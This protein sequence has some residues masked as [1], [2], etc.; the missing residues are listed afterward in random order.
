MEL[1]QLEAFER[2][3]REGSFTRTA[4]LLGLT[5]PA[6]STRIQLLETQLGGALFTRGGRRLTLT[7]LGEHF[8]PYAQRILALRDDSLQAVQDFYGGMRG[9]VKLAAPTPFL[10]SYLIDVLG[11]FRQSHPS[12][13]IWIRERNKTTIFDLLLDHVMVLGLVNAPVFDPSFRQL[14]RLRDPIVPVVGTTHPLAAHAN[15]LHLQDLYEHTVFRVSLFPQ[16]TAFVDEL[17]EHARR[18]SGGAII[19]VPM[20][21]ARRL[22]IMGQGVTFLPLSYVRNA[23][24]AGDFL[25]LTIHDMPALYS[26]PV[27]IAFRGRELDDANRAFEATLRKQWQHLLVE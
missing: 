9:Q 15:D 22:V 16:M 13:D 26:E 2:A 25:Q 21:M 12:V 20:V 19:A 14:L 1:A 11:A 7:P 27:L 18:G 23:I 17:A 10:L 8:L 4:E 6:V 3:A 5:Q 24:A